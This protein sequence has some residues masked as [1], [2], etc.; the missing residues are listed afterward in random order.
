[1][2]PLSAGFLSDAIG[3]PADATTFAGVVGAAAV[4][5]AGFVATC[6]AAAAGR[7]SPHVI[8]PG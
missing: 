1:V 7:R 2:L 4:L 8:I 5:G 3:L 6:A